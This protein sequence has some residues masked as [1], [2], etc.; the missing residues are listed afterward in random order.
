MSAGWDAALEQ[1]EQAD[2]PA[3]VYRTAIRL[4][5]RAIADGGTFA[6]DEAG[7]LDI[8]QTN[9]E[10]TMRSHLVQLASAGIIRYKRRGFVII[11]FLAWMGEDEILI[12]QRSLLS[13]DEGIRALS[14]QNDG[15]MA[16][17]LIAERSN[18]EDEVPIRALSD[19]NTRAERSKSPSTSH[20]RSGRWVGRSLSTTQKRKKPTYPPKPSQTE[21]LLAPLQQLALDLLEDSDVGV[22]HETALMLV[23]T[24]PVQDI[25]RTVDKWLPDAKA[26]KVGPGVIPHRLE[27][28]QPSRAATVNLS[29]AFRDSDLFHRHRLPDEMVADAER[30]NYSVDGGFPADEQRRKYS[31]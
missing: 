21:P 13:Q 31:L 23:L 24:K 8:C 11:S 28:L 3:T 16:E 14:D 5:R 17:D 22:L 4:L 27:K 6:L 18:V 10:G 19:Q 1:I 30:K 29:P 15:E 25:Y 12:A 9:A 26:G 2:L 7:L 20:A